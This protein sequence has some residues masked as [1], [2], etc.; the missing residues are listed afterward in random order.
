[1]RELLFDPFFWF[2][3]PLGLALVSVIPIW[4]VRDRLFVVFLGALSL[5]LVVLSVLATA[6]W[7][8]FFKD[9]LGPGFITST[10]WTAILRFWEGFG[11]PLAIAAIEGLAIA[12]IFRRRLG[13]LRTLAVVPTVEEQGRS[14][15]PESDR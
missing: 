12:V 13:T 6:F 4:L 2:S 7:S 1:V 11:V 9:G 10:G 15:G 5:G 3:V 8:W 14:P